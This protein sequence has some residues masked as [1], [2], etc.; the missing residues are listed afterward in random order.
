MGQE[1]ACD[2]VA[3]R[4]LYIPI[5]PEAVEYERRVGEC[6]RTENDLGFPWFD[7]E[8][9]ITRRAHEFHSCFSRGHRRGEPDF[10]DQV[11]HGG[12]CGEKKGRALAGSDAPLLLLVECEQRTWRRE[13]GEMHDRRFRDGRD[14]H[15]GGIHLMC[16]GYSFIMDTMLQALVYLDLKFAVGGT[17]ISGLGDTE[18]FLRAFEKLWLL[19]CLDEGLWPVAHE[20]GRGTR[21]P[22][23]PE[24]RAAPKDGTRAVN[25]LDI[26][27][28]GFPGKGEWEGFAWTA[29]SVLEWERK[30]LEMVWEPEVY[31]NQPSQRLGPG[32]S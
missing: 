15:R 5:L 2:C 4:S 26:A 8:V 11:L 29:E 32:R 16:S 25:E 27:P 6:T 9:R 31:E 7:W 10:C 3:G 21:G 18:K 17:D 14:S 19:G 12:L 13:L 30:I 28:V 23:G 20:R 24:S 22:R 1:V